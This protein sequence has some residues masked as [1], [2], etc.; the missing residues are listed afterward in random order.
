MALLESEDLPG[1]SFLVTDPRAWYPD[2][3]WAVSDGD[4]AALETPSADNLELLVIATVSQEPFTITF[5]LLGPLVV[6]RAGGRARQVIQHQT[7]YAAAHP[8]GP[9]LQAAL[10]G[11]SARQGGA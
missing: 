2:Y 8:V 4:L 7:D 9:D 1:L 11:G 3:R 10:N 6:N 5:N